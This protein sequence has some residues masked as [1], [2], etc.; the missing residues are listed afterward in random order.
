VTEIMSGVVQEGG[1][2]TLAHIRG[3]R[4]AGK[5][6]TAEK[7]DPVTR[8]YSRELHLSSFVGFAPAE[9]PRFVTVVM[10]DEPR[11]TVYGGAT[12]GPAWRAIMEAA[13]IE[14]GLLT[15]DS[16]AATEAPPVVRPSVIA[17]PALV[18]RPD[19][20]PEA[21]REQAA[22]R[23]VGMTARQAIAAAE[24]QGLEVKLHGSGIV[25]SQDPKPGMPLEGTSVVTLQ[26]AEAL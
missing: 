6:G 23:Y 26:L 12:A 7:V 9:S 19:E 8:R 3:V 17:A 2:G 25:V 18:E 24:R 4:V 5:T 21:V 10:I 1:T 16:T 22:Q 20:R 14:E 13:L 15:E 11:G